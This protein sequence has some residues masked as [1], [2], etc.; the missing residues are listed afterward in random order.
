MDPDQPAEGAPVAREYVVFGPGGDLVVTAVAELEV[1][2]QGE[3]IL[4]DAAGGC[5]AIVAQDHWWHVTPGDAPEDQDEE[6]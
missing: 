2:G 6:G 3:L 1:G 4:K 5:A